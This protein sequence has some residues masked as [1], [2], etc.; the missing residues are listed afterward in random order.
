MANY[1]STINSS[2]IGSGNT[3]DNN[4]QVVLGNSS[5][6]QI[7]NSGDGVADL[8]SSA[9]KFKDCYL[10]GGL[11]TSGQSSFNFIINSQFNLGGQANFD[12]EVNIDGPIIGAPF[13]LIFAATDEVS[14]IT[15]TGQKMIL[16][17]LQIF[18]LQVRLNFLPI[19]L[20]VVVLM[21][22]IKK[23]GTAVATIDQ[24]SLL[25]SNTASVET[26]V[27][28]DIVSLE[29]SNIGSGSAIGLKCYLIGKTN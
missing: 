5:V 25:V 7:V 12:G 26:Y 4:N 21:L 15:T 22:V 9:H 16:R 20:V 2:C 19:L 10:A 1:F 6:N 24:D 27:E 11:T 23:N 18:L 29:M 17:V 28:V 13:N 8:R 3:T 14:T